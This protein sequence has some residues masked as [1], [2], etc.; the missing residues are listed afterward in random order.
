MPG[1]PWM[2]SGV[3]VLMSVLIW[4]YSS[5]VEIAGVVMGVGKFLSSS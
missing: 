2:N 1:L 4:S 5:V 3:S